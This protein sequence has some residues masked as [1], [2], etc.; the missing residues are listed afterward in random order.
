MPS[1]ISYMILPCNQYFNYV[2]KVYVVTS[3]NIYE[4]N[5]MFSNG[6]CIHT[7]YFHVMKESRISWNEN[8]VNYQ[9]IFYW[10]LIIDIVGPLQ[11]IKLSVN[12]CA[13]DTVL[14]KS[15]MGN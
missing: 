9:H 14:M 4:Q 15:C 8:T 13:E 6:A 1:D 12:Q 10:S 5:K 3:Y 11:G 2:F 7:V